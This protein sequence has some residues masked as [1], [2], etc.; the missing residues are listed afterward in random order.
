MCLKLSV[1]HSWTWRAYLS[2]FQCP[3]A[4]TKLTCDNFH[5]LFP[6]S[7][8]MLRS[9]WPPIHQISHQKIARSRQPVCWALS[10]SLIHSHS[11][12][13]DKK[14]GILTKCVY[15]ATCPTSILF[16]SSDRMS[17]NVKLNC[18]IT[19]WTTDLFF[20]VFLYHVLLVY[21]LSVNKHFI[22]IKCNSKQTSNYWR[23]LL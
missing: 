19:I 20:I 7:R 17:I 16:F 14:T 21:V 1:Q 15:D 2:L 6:L 22:A 13:K 5:C 12:K 23:D 18:V 9:Q 4:M 3:M 10:F 8:K 11:E